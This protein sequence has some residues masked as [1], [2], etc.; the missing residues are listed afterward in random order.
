MEQTAHLKFFILLLSLDTPSL[1]FSPVLWL[2]VRLLGERWGNKAG[3][4]L[5]VLEACYLFFY[6]A[7][8]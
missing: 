3:F 4:C 6:L 8:T 2:L 1:I 7:G 5:I